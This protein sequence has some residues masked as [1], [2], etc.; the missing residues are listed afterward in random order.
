MEKRNREREERRLNVEK[1]KKEKEMLKNNQLEKTR[2][3][4]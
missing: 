4:R 2:Q 1:V 3:D